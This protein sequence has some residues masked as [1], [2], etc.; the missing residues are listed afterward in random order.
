VHDGE[1]DSVVR[2]FVGLSCE[3]WCFFTL[4]YVEQLFPYQD[5]NVCTQ[6]SFFSV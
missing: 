4:H 6:W 1:Y 5:C 2:I 3:L